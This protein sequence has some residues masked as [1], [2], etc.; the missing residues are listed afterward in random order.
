MINIENIIKKINNT[1]MSSMIEA[2][3]TSEGVNHLTI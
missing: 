1:E 2:I 3:T